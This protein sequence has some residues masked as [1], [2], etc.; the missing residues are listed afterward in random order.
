MGPAAAAKAAEL[1]IV[2]REDLPRFE[3]STPTLSEFDPHFVP[4][5]FDCLKLIREEWD[6]KTQ[7]VLEVLLSGALGS[8]KSILLA[9]II[10]THCLM[11]KRAR[12][13]I[14]RRAMPDLKDTLFNDILEHLGETLVEGRDYRVNKAKGIVFANGSEIIMKSWADRKA[15][16][17]RSMKISLLAVEE[18]TE[19]DEQDKMAVME[20][21]QRLGRLSHVPE[22]LF[23]S[24]TNPDEPSHWA[25]QY[26]IVPATK[27]PTGSKRVF[28]SVTQDNPFLPELYWRQLLE[29]LD[30]KMAD[31]M[32]RGRWISI[33]GETVYHSYDL[34]LHE[35]EYE[36][37]VNPAYPIVVSFDFNIGAGKPL[38]CTFSQYAPGKNGRM[39][40]HFFAEVVIE[41][42]RT[43]SVL[44]E[45]WNRGLFK[46]P[47]MYYIRG[48]ASGK[49]GDTR[50][51]LDDYLLI[52]D[53]LKRKQR[54]DG[55]FLMFLREVP[56]SNPPLRSRHNIAN[57]WLLNDLGEV[58][59]LV[60]PKCRVLREGFKLNK[61]KKGADYL[62]D[63]SKFYQHVTT[64]ATYDIYFEAM[65]AR[66]G[67]STVTQL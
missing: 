5:Q 28:Y 41:G 18:L 9:H 63:D 60:Y 2:Y 47:V 66:R 33:L 53:W 11:Y 62:E 17:A 37:A 20:L 3:G 51:N 43:Q 10:V 49:H 22:Q 35:P 1:R 42:A 36:Y 31:R 12:A 29:E 13:C 58:R 16:K 56:L 65:K 8:A 64:A 38:S 27:N 67:R 34:K 25:Y 15:K 54:E 4:W 44:E 46:T 39:Q 32:I 19:N 40:K 24:A 52:D 48:D 14:A 21:R 23:I 59:V 50:M 6:Y 55:S 7:G 61:L 57:A 26:F 45:A 30:S